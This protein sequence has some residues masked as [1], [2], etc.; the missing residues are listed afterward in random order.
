[1]VL[2]FRDWVTWQAFF[3]R[4]SRNSSSA[5]AEERQGEYGWGIPSLKKATPGFLPTPRPSTWP[6]PNRIQMMTG[7][8]AATFPISSSVCMIFLIRAWEGGRKLGPCHLRPRKGCW[9]GGMR[10][11]IREKGGGGPR[12]RESTEGG[13]ASVSPNTATRPPPHP[14]GLGPEPPGS[15]AC[16]SRAWPRAH[17]REPRVILFLLARHLRASLAAPG[18]APPSAASRPPGLLAARLSRFPRVLVP[19]APPPPLPTRS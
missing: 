8:A 18:P 5:R 2:A 10:E 1:M 14:A 9:G 16:S 19:P 17:R 4:D 13:G 12:C 7:T 15:P 3:N 11:G 6:G